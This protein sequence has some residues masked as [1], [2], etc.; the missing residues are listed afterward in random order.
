M[1]GAQ[2]S[3]YLTHAETVIA[4]P[5]PVS[6]APSGISGLPAPYV[7]VARNTVGHDVLCGDVHGHFTKLQAA[8]DAIGFDPAAGDRLFFVGDLPDRGPESDHARDWLARTWVHAVRGN[9][10]QMA[11]DYVDGQMDAELYLMNGGAW[12]IAQ[13]RVEQ[14]AIADAFSA[15]PIAIELET[16]TGPVGIV[17]ADCPF[18]QFGDLEAELQGPGMRSQTV[19]NVCMWNRDRIGSMRG[20]HVTDVR[21]VVVGHTP[22]PNW[23]TLGNTIYIDTMA[24]RGGE[25]TL[26]SAETLQPIRVPLRNK[27]P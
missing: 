21:A 1:S 26:L 22:M 13:P 7:R 24:W 10:E 14:C 20:D 9:H 17:H 27:L 23:T 2:A 15:L 4:A 8:L 16:A 5:S 6:V 11:I 18:D 3:G 12:F 19:A 25:F